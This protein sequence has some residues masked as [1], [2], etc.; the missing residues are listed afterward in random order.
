MPSPHTAASLLSCPQ[1]QATLPAACG[2]ADSLSGAP[3]RP[4][5]TCRWLKPRAAC[6]GRR[7]G[8]RSTSGE[9]CVKAGLGCGL[10]DA[11]QASG[12]Q[13]S[14]QPAGSLGFLPKRY[15]KF[16]AWPPPAPQPQVCAGE[17]ERHPAVRPADPV[18]AGVGACCVSCAA[19]Q[20]NCCENSVLVARDCAAAAPSWPEYSQRSR[21]P[22]AHVVQLMSE[23]KS[24]VRA[25]SQPWT[26][27]YRWSLEMGVCLLACTAHVHPLSVCHTFAGLPGT[28][29]TCAT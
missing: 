29:Q 27:A 4:G 6:C 22:C 17:R 18:S 14:R 16:L 21:V 5:A 26:S 24:R 9:G 10:G 3:P 8:T 23:S 15:R 2:V 20:L 13:A 12:R 19:R 28:R 11:W 1:V 25:C 7:S